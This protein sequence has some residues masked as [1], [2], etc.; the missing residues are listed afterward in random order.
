M[1]SNMPRLLICDDEPDSVALLMSY[2]DEQSIDILVSLDGQDALQKA[3][4]S[5][6]D[7]ILLD[8]TMPRLNGFEVCEQLKASQITQ[9]IPVIFL[10]GRNGLEDKLKGFAI[11]AVDYITKPFSEAEVLARVGVHLHARHQARKMMAIANFRAVD[12]DLADDPQE[13][14]FKRALSLIEARLTQPPGLV[15]LSRSVG[16]N[17]RKLTDIFRHKVGLSVFDY[18]NQRRLECSRQ[19]LDSSSL[20]VR[21]IADQLGY[22]NPGDF[23]RAFRRH[24]GVTPRE[25]R[26]SVGAADDGAQDEAQH[27]ETSLN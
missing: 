19:L 18:I 8:V 2:L 22:K 9:S 3:V 7:L 14:I 11:G 10:S 21:Q 23:T 20:Q 25:Y 26:R 4:G 27:D 15:E 1:L 24:Y 5:Q 16:V 12:F 13:K 17:E 6:P